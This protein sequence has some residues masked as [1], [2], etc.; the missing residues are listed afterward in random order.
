MTN[1][2]FRRFEEPLSSS[3]HRCASESSDADDLF[4]EISFVVDT[5]AD[6]T[7]LSPTDGQRLNAEPVR[8]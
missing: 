6:R 8:D 2:Y 1:G 3:L 7:L 5:G 4:F